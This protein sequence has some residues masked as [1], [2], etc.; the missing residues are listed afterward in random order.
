MLEMDNIQKKHQYT[1]SVKVDNSNA[2]G[3]LL[4]MKEKLISENELSSENG[5]SFTAYACIQEN[6]LVVAA[7]QVK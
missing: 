5:L 3:L 2:K 1:V 4:K 7:D 6:I